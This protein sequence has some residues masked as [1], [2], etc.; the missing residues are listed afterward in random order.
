[1]RR[2]SK[3]TFIIFL[4]NLIFCQILVLAQEK[5]DSVTEISPALSLVYLCTSNDTV[6]L[7]AALNARTEKGYFALENAEIGF[8][9]SAGGESKLLG[10]ARTDYEG[11]AILK[12]PVKSGIPLDREGKTT[13]TATFAGKGQYLPGSETTTAKLA[14]ITVTFSKA[15][16]IR[17]INVTVTHADNNG[18][19]MPVTK[20]TVNI[21]IPRL[22]SSLKIGEITLDENGK[23]TIECPSHIVGDSLGNIQ[24]IAKI[25]E[26]DI[27][28][29]VQGQSSITWGIP[30][31]YYL[32]ERPTRE[33]WTPVAPVWMIITLIIMLTGVWAHYIYAVIQLIMIKRHSKEKKQYF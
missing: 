15:D 16:S 11:N 25:E 31:Q 7:T 9:A 29:N 26:N 21:Y 18:K 1:M 10:K 19:I 33:L 5:K 28:G 32:A 13:Y 8:S 30:K 24:V 6:I 12:V 4:I 22:F 14:R 17:N 23:G 27:F 2:Y 20:E 3:V